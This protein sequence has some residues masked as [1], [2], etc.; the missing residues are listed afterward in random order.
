LIHHDH[1]GILAHGGYGSVGSVN[2]DENIWE[3]IKEGA[4]KPPSLY[5][6]NIL[7]EAA[8]Y[9]MVN[10]P[11]DVS[12]EE[13][14]AIPFSREQ[15]EG[16]ERYAKWQERQR[17]IRYVAGIFEK[18]CAEEYEKAAAGQQGFTWTAEDEKKHPRNEG[19]EWTEKGG[20]GK[21]TGAEK[22]GSKSPVSLLL[23]N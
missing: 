22:S 1:P 11:P 16:A 10:R 2:P 14:E 8:A 18:Y 4:L 12:R 15:R 9:V 13:L 7:R 19:G 6:E 3:L 23:L 21:G 20:E 17:Q 5:D